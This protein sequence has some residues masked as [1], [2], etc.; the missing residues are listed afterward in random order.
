MGYPRFKNDQYE[1]Y[2]FHWF[3]RRTMC[4]R[5]CR[6]CK[7]HISVI[8]FATQLMISSIYQQEDRVL[9]GTDLVALH[10]G[11]IS[12][13]K[14]AYIVD[15]YAYVV[16]A[17]E[18]EEREIGRLRFIETMRE[19]PLID[20]NAILRT[21]PRAGTYTLFMGPGGNELLCTLQTLYRQVMKIETICDDNIF[22]VLCY[23]LLC[24]HLNRLVLF[25]PDVTLLKYSVVPSNLVSIIVDHNRKLFNGIVL[26]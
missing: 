18:E 19:F 25:T 13:E 4:D 1:S 5:P 14:A 7:I 6:V 11:G 24:W 21:V 26:S 15:K 10:I 3:E 9:N 17:T 22:F 23:L 20:I 2:F 12:T 16:D 8:K